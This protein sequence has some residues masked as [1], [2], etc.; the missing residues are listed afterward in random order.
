LPKPPVKKSPVF[1]TLF[2]NLTKPIKF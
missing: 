2:I 1:L